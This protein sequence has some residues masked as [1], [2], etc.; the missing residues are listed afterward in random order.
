M[1]TVIHKHS[2]KQYGNNDAINKVNIIW[3]PL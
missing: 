3:E 2:E 1:A